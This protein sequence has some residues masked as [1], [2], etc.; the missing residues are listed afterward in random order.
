MHHPLLAPAALLNPAIPVHPDVVR[1]AIN[2]AEHTATPQE[3]AEF[4]MLCANQ[5]DEEPLANAALLPAYFALLDPVDVDLVAGMPEPY[6]RQ[7]F[8]SLLASMFAVAS[9]ACWEELQA[10][11]LPHVWS[12]VWPWIR[13]F[14]DVTD[15]FLSLE[16]S[17]YPATPNVFPSGQRAATF[18]IIMR[19]CTQIIHPVDHPALSIVLSKVWVAVVRVE[20]LQGMYDVSE[21]LRAWFLPSWND[22]AFGALITGAGGT[23]ALARLLVEHLTI[24]AEHYVRFHVDDSIYILCP[25]LHFAAVSTGMLGGRSTGNAEFRDAVVLL[26]VVGP[27]TRLASLVSASDHPEARHSL[28]YSLGP[29]MYQL[30]VNPDPACVADAL[31]GGILTVVSNSAHTSAV[32]TTISRLL[33]S[34]VRDI[35][36]KTTIHHAN[37]RRLCSAFWTID[38]LPT[39][40][41]FT[42]IEARESWEA[43]RS[44]VYA[45]SQAL[46]SRRHSTDGRCIRFQN[47]RALSAPFKCSG[48]TCVLYCS[49]QCQ[50][51]HWAD[52]HRLVCVSFS[53]LKDVLRPRG[54]PAAS[55]KERIIALELNSRRTELDALLAQSPYYETRRFCLL[56]DFTSGDCVLECRPLDDLRALVDLD[57]ARHVIDIAGLT[58]CMMV[59]SSGSLTSKVVHA[60]RTI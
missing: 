42:D 20:E 6:R 30:A 9:I 59:T 29:V 55:F 51:L 22:S 13:Y 60:I 26:Q 24:A 14:M 17:A 25:I 3:C 32:P 56:L 40:P 44:L 53:L 21:L 50:K 5:Y 4:A 2:V 27:L 34:L 11:L 46:Q 49:Q 41:T 43:L 48:C 52:G 39:A 15:A 19:A 38:A 37:L 33:L 58:F 10:P 54:R 47:C 1:K 8:L 31:R 28:Y 16:S 12:R 18:A 45:R 7:R 23:R 57:A 35:L 36:P